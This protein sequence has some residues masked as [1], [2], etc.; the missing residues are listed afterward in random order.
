MQTVLLSLYP[1]TIFADVYVTAVYH[2]LPRS[3]CMPCTP[4]QD[5]GKEHGSHGITVDGVFGLLLTEKVVCSHC[6]KETHKVP[7]HYEHLV[8]V[9]IA[10]FNMA[11]LSL[12]GAHM[13]RLLAFLFAQ[14]QKY[15]D[16]DEGG[17][18]EPNVS[19]CRVVCLAAAAVDFGS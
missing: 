8:V 15:C 3:T 14:E 13:D 19:A 17:C 16:K 9:N 6:G 18:G 1:H 11:A 2:M 12:E 4:L 5:P 7:R 10:S